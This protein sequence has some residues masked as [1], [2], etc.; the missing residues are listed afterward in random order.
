MESFIKIEQKAESKRKS[1]R[2]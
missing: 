1:L 2:Y